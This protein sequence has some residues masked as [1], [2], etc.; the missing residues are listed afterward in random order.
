MRSRRPFPVHFL[1]SGCTVVQKL[2]ILQR[3]FRP[4][5]P[6]PQLLP[7]VPLDVRQAPLEWDLIQRGVVFQPPRHRRPSQLPCLSV[8]LRLWAA[9]QRRG[10]RPSSSWLCVTVTDCGRGDVGLHLH[11]R[12]TAHRHVSFH[13]KCQHLIRTDKV[14]NRVTSLYHPAARLHP[15]DNSV[16]DAYGR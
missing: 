15:R 7:P 4:Q 12:H 9:T 1:Q 2:W 5:R 14:W 6:E 8:P 3:H 11:W 10:G 16:T 13:W